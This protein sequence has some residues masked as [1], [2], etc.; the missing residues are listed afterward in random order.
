MKL[1]EQKYIKIPTDFTSLHD[2]KELLENYELTSKL[3]NA[4]NDYQEHYITSNMKT[5]D[6]VLE[7]IP[8]TQY[9]KYSVKYRGRKLEGDY[10]YDSNNDIIKQKLYQLLKFYNIKDSKIFLIDTINKVIDICLWTANNYKLKSESLRYLGGTKYTGKNTYD[11]DSKTR[12]LSIKIP[13]T[14]ID[15]HAVGGVMISTGGG[16]RYLSGASSNN[17]ERTGIEEHQFCIKTNKY[18]GYK[19]VI[20]ES[21]ERGWIQK[22]SYY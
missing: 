6:E 10:Q 17:Y 21:P 16:G 11:V 9:E 18:L 15:S 19:G 13:Y 2:L 1:K 7:Y 5:L 8:K 3:Q 20:E 14:F 12:I 22:T 4:L